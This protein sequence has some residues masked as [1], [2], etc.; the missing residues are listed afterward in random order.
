MNRRKRNHI[1]SVL[2][3]FLIGVGVG[4]SVPIFS[5]QD[6]ETSNDLEIVESVTSLGALDVNN[7]DIQ[8]F[9]YN[10]TLYNGNSHEILIKS[11]KPEFSQNFSEIV[12][13]EN[14]EQ[15]VGKSIEPEGAVQIEGSN[16]LN[17]TGLSKEEISSMEPLIKSI[18]ITSVTSH[19][20]S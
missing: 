17:I 8:V 12:I 7:T 11:F 16:Q 3:V 13:T 5:I 4:F 6:V 1:L 15:I 14:N 18:N 10:F 20:L 19:S 9:S 2:I